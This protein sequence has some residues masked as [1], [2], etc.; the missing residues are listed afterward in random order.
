MFSALERYIPTLESYL[1]QESDNHRRTFIDQRQDPTEKILLE[2]LA[3]P[4]TDLPSFRQKLSKSGLEYNLRNAITDYKLLHC[5]QKTTLSKNSDIFLQLSKKYSTGS[6]DFSRPTALITQQAEQGQMNQG[7]SL[8]Q[9]E[10]SLEKYLQEKV[11]QRQD[12]IRSFSDYA[13][14]KLS[15]KTLKGLSVSNKEYLLEKSAI[16]FNFNPE[17]MS[18]FLA[19]FQKQKQVSNKNYKLTTQILS[20]LT[21]NQLFKLGE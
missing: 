17:F 8:L 7:S 11:R 20:T 14:S 5:A 13:V 4:L 2:I 21:K 18:T 6:Y 19:L 3:E 9:V 12:V 10:N 1:L 15:Q 16:I